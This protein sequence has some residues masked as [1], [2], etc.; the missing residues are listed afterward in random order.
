MFD[1]LL[2]SSTVRSRWSHA[3]TGALI[4]HIMLIAAAVH[5]RG[6]SRAAPPPAS[7]DTIRMELALVRPLLSGPGTRFTSGSGGDGFP[8]A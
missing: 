2:A 4:L 5:G 6:I 7:R 8:A 1:I 3:V